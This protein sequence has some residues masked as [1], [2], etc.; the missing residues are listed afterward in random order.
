MENT[1]SLFFTQTVQQLGPDNSVESWVQADYNSLHEV[2]TSTDGGMLF[3][4]SSNL[5]EVAGVPEGDPEVV[6]EDDPMATLP[7]VPSWAADFDPL[8][9]R[10]FLI[11]GKG[12]LRR[13]LLGDTSEEEIQNEGK[14]SLLIPQGISQLDTS[15][16]ITVDT[17][18]TIDLIEKSIR[19][20]SLEID[21]PLKESGA[22][23][24]Y[25][26]DLANTSISIDYPLRDIKGFNRSKWHYELVRR[27]KEI[28]ATKLEERRVIKLA[29]VDLPIRVNYIRYAGRAIRANTEVVYATDLDSFEYYDRDSLHILDNYKIEVQ[30]I[31]KG[32]TFIRYY[33]AVGEIIS[34]SWAAPG[35]GYLPSSVVGSREVMNR[36]RLAEIGWALLA[37][38]AQ[39][40]RELTHLVLV[41]LAYIWD[42]YI[43]IKSDVPYGLPTTIPRIS[44]TK[45][46]CTVDLERSTYDNAWCGYCICLAIKFLQGG[47]I[48]SVYNVPSNVIQLL[49][50]M[51]RLVTSLVDPIE[52]LAYKGYAESTYLQEDIDLVASFVTDLF[53]S[54]LLSLDYNEYF[55]NVN[56]RLRLGL[57]KVYQNRKYYTALTKDL[58]GNTKLMILTHMQMWAARFEYEN[59]PNY[60]EAELKRSLSNDP[61][62]V[63]YETPIIA[64]LLNM[65]KDRYPNITIDVDGGLSIKG[66]VKVV[67]GLEGDLVP[68]GLLG[69]TTAE[70]LLTS[71]EILKLTEFSLDYRQPYNIH[72]EE[73]YLYRT[74][75]YSEAQRMTPY[76]YRWFTHANPKAY[77]SRYGALIYGGVSPTIEFSNVYNRTR[78]GLDPSKAQGEELEGYLWMHGITKK[79]GQSDGYLRKLLG[80]YINNR[81]GTKTSIVNRLTETYATYLFDLVIGTLPSVL[82][83]P[84]TGE[85][86]VIKS[87]NDLY[88]AF[89]EHPTWLEVKQNLYKQ[90]LVKEVTWESYA[91]IINIMVYA[92]LPSITSTIRTIMGAGIELQVTNTVHTSAYTSGY[93]SNLNIL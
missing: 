77:Q 80:V 36:V 73:A 63:Y 74:Q 42:N 12:G 19:D 33:S 61:P 53:L 52:G 54:E 51:G 89:N 91:G 76:G 75:C 7:Y 59:I 55:H 67:T 82:V 68:T 6:E 39:K 3:N 64:Y 9:M 66:E 14:V 32:V 2:Y 5:K 26:D 13:F 20:Y 78:V 84:V 18:V 28:V 11:L 69:I 17:E 41:E 93:S 27:D 34:E 15:T 47:K 37:L 72:A 88:V 81:S 30:N 71:I 50:N 46:S 58:P 25:Y 87:A 38:I 86:R 70:L 43:N 49:T 4:C 22:I 48:K 90:K 24:T 85:E 29:T 65:Y 79:V 21:T 8:Y 57:N 92:A 16:P 62:I 83:N 44:S 10:N 60:L 23:E 45:V 56:V 35:R 31:P 40:D 1:F